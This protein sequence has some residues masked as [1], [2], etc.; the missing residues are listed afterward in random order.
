MPKPRNFS[1]SESRERMVVFV[2]K[3]RGYSCSRS[4]SHCLHR[5][6][7]DSVLHIEDA[8]DVDQETLG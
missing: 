3:R 6:G 5:P 2:R 8:I 4:Q 7:N 1:T